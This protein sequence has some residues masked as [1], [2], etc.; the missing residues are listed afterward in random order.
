[1]SKLRLLIVINN[2]PP[3]LAGGAAVIGDMCYG[4]AARGFDVTVRCAYPY[5]PEWRDK[6]GRNGFSIWRHE[7]RGVHVERYGLF[8]PYNPNTLWQRLLH[9]LSFL[10]SLLRSL[11][12]GRHFDVVMAYCPAVSCLAFGALNKLIWGRPLWLNVQDLAA[13]AATASGLVRRPWIGTLLRNVQSWFFNRADIWSTISPVMVERLTRMRKRQQPLLFI[14]NWLNESLQLAIES[15]CASS[16]VKQLHTPVRLLYSGNI[17]R[18]QDL[19]ALLKILQQAEH[20]FEFAVHGSGAAAPE[21]EAWIRESS[22]PRFRFGPFLD[23][24]GFAGVLNWTDFFVITETG[25]SGASFMPS[26]LIPGICSGTPILAICDAAG[27]LGVEV[28]TYGLGPWLT[29]DKADS[30]PD[31]LSAVGAEPNRY[32]DWV[33]NSLRRAGSYQRK[34]IIDRIEAGLI[35]LFQQSLPHTDI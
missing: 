1:M 5:Y 30:L 26:K 11:H 27:P 7:D 6:S 22:D 15:E 24:R 18:K 31:I 34:A 17:G 33:T 8:I 35:M 9:E 21:V 20:P 16:V 32:T 10:L 29:W 28:L 3:D 4:L 14:P 12:R 25:D 19:L 2:F 13:E 23:E